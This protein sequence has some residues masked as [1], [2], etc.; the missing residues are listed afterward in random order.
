MNKLRAVRGLYE[1]RAVIVK[2]KF[3]KNIGSVK[4]K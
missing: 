2:I 4:P 3:N 1:A